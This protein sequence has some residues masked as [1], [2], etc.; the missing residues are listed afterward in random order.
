[1]RKEFI[2]DLKRICQVVNKKTAE[3]KLWTLEKKIEK[4]IYIIRIP[5]SIA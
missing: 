5:D 2:A 3:S 4:T 1:M